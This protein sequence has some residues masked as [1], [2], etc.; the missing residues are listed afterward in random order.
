MAKTT[1]S[2]LY[3]QTT[4]GNK[5][6]ARKH[7]KQGNVLGKLAKINQRKLGNLKGQYKSS[8]RDIEAKLQRD[9]AL[10]QESQAAAG[11]N[12][13]RQGAD[14]DAAESDTSFANLAN[15][16]RERTQSL[17]QVAAQGGGETDMLKAQGAAL[18]N[19]SQNQGQAQRSYAD[20]LSSINTSISDTNM[21]NKVNFQNTGEQAD[22]DTRAA[23]NQ[24]KEAQGQ[25]LNEQANIYG[26][27]SELY[28]T[29]STSAADQYATNRTSESSRGTKNTKNTTTSVQGGKEIATT[30]SK[31]YGKRQDRANRDLLKNARKL[32]DLN[33][34][35]YDSNVRSADQLGF[36]AID[37]MEQKQNM[38][39]LGTAQK[40]TK[41]SGVEGA[42]LRKW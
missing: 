34:E 12:Y 30:L 38:N 33:S 19:W 21:S 32:A 29:A 10:L 6:E 8:T 35:V 42:T 31:N 3:K 7:A 9:L 5:S 13:G 2:S 22:A 18:R 14:N 25:V 24:W 26:Q 23:F 41:I 15:M 1:S 20:T 4:K 11:A 36:A 37:S 39:Q 27:Q 17:A 16:R 28:G 40:L